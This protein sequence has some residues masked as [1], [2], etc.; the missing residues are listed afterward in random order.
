MTFGDLF[1]GIGGISL[2]L[3]RAGMVCKWQVE[4]DDFCQKVLV[5]HWPSVPRYGD[6]R[7]VDFERVEPVDL[8]AGGFPCQPHSIAGKQRGAEDDRDLWPEFRR[9]VASLRPTWVLCENV[10]GIRGTIL[11]QVLADLEHLGYATWV[12]DIPAAAFDAPHRRERVFVVAYSERNRLA[13]SKL[14]TASCGKGNEAAT[15]ESF[16]LPAWPPGPSEIARIPRTTDGLPNRIHRLRALGNAV[17]PQ[18]AEWLGRQIIKAN[19][20]DCD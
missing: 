1:A 6:I 2:G 10:P 7:E 19:E 16:L 14:R 8:V 3:E 20:A 15:P 17:V 13:L 5:K 9:A 4:I 11:D 12:P 18:V